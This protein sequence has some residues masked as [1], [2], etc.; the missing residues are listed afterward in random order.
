MNI[1]DVQRFLDMFGPR[2]LAVAKRIQELDAQ[3]DKA[4]EELSEAQQKEFEDVR[5][6]QRGAAVT[7]TVL[8][9]TDGTAELMLTYVVSNASWTPLYDVRA[10]IAKTPEDKS[11][12]ALHYP[13]YRKSR[14][15][16]LGSQPQNL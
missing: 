9:E 10:S 16:E 1:E 15:G 7:V 4:Q 14:L 13:L 12:I 8:A 3:I 2:Q 11:T 6:A 5:G